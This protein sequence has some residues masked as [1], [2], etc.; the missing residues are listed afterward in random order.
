MQSISECTSGS[1]AAS[2]TACTSICVLMP[3]EIDMK[4]FI[5]FASTPS[6]GMMATPFST[7]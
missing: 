7:V 4:R 6:T 3:P 5:F 1:A 2:V